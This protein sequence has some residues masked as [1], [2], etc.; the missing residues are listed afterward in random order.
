MRRTKNIWPMSKSSIWLSKSSIWFLHFNENSLWLTKI[1]NNVPKIPENSRWQIK[2]I[3]FNIDKVRR[4]SRSKESNP[5]SKESN[6][7]CTGKESRTPRWKNTGDDGAF[8]TTSS[9]IFQSNV[10]IQYSEWGR[11]KEWTHA[12]VQKNNTM[13]YNTIKCCGYPSTLLYST[14][15]YTRLHYSTQ[16][17]P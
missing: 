2:K 11:K 17:Q 15:L 16:S 3:V 5:R 9:W 4:V 6:P 7:R 8:P 14:L 10:R 12:T 1:M 13:Q